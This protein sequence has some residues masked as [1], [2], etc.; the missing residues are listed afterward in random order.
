MH[1]AIVKCQEEET[2]WIDSLGED[3]LG[4]VEKSIE[5]MASPE[6]VWEMLALD[7]LP[8]WMDVLE[9]KSA[10]YISERRT[11]KDKYGKGASAHIIEKRWEYDLEI[12]ESLENEKMTVHSKGKYAYTTTYILKPIDEGTKLTYLSEYG[13]RGILGKTFARL[14]AATL[15]KQVDQA[16]GKL[17]S[18]L[19]K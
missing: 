11:P 17:K 13:T 8:E 18:I 19:E 7:R 5:I 3:L 4:R 10:K 14:F 9:M 1:G 16:L 2:F 12:T 6:K 15:E